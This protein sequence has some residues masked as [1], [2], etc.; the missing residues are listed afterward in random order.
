MSEGSVTI[1]QSPLVVGSVDSLKQLARLQPDGLEGL[2]DLLEV[3]LDGMGSDL[4]AL[5]IE[6]DRFRDVALLL[7]ARCASQGG[8]TGMSA[9][10]RADLLLALSSRA[11]WI[12]VELESFDEMEDAIHRIRCNGVGLILSHH[13]F[14]QTPVEDAIR[15]LVDLGEE[16]DIIKL[17]FH[18]NSVEDM[19]RCTNILRNSNHPMAMMGMGKLAPVSRLLYAQHGS[20]LNYGYLGDGP[21]APGQWPAGLLREAITALEPIA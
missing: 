15:Q 12:D 2:C 21:T 13:D 10:R 6:L 17:A 20:L 7:T 14:Q 8:L 9:A 18:H 1:P 19:I 4:D 3:R 16:A 11:S 5:E